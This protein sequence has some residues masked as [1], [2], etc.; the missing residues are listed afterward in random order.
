MIP[1]P[2]LEGGGK[3]GNRPG[4]RAV[5]LCP[6]TLRS[7]DPF[8]PHSGRLPQLQLHPSSSVRMEMVG[9]AVAGV[10]AAMALG[11]GAHTAWM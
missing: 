9:T 3:V 7:S 6:L 10:A 2:V 4:G 5:S 8:L 1:A 11:L